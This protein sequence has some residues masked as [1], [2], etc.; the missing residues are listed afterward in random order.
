MLFRSNLDLE[1]L[2]VYGYYQWRIIEPLALTAGITYDRLRFPDNALN[3]PLDNAEVT[4]DQISPKAG[5]IF[6]PGQRTT[7]RALY[8]RSLGGLFNENSFRLEPTQIAGLNQTF[9][10]VIPESA[11]GPL[12]GAH[13]ETYSASLDQSFDTGTFLGI[14]GELLN[15]HGDRGVGVFTNAFFA[16][17]VLPNLYSTTRQTLDFHEKSLLLTV[18]QLIG[19]EWSVGARYRASEANLKSD[20]PAV[21]D[22][23]LW[24]VS[25]P[26]M[27]DVSG[28]LQ[29]LTLSLNYNH[30]CG[31]F[32]QFR[33]Q[34]TK[35]TNDGYSPALAGDNFWQHDILA[36]Y[37]FPQRRFEV[38]VGVLNLTDQDYRLNPLNLYAELPR[39]R[40]FT[41]GAK[42]NF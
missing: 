25:D 9:R 29:Q 40:T 20:F 26:K 2:T 37:R 13:I 41:A 16:A 1:R 6:T 11:A 10:S 12:P 28:V 36:G 33:S 34:W 31:F 21:P 15:S 39:H 5:L 7:M 32:G 30:R 18:N 14:A 24:Q 19:Q 23:A 8:S 35:Q 38:H 22:T 4:T 42:F 27:T 3:A 17:L